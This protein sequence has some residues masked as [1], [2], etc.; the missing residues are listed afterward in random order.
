MSAKNRKIKKHFCS[1][2]TGHSRDRSYAEYIYLYSCIYLGIFLYCFVLLSSF[3][4]SS[5]KFVLGYDLL[6]FKNIDK[7][8]FGVLFERMFLITPI[9]AVWK[10]QI[11]VVGLQDFFFFFPFNNKVLTIIYLGMIFELDKHIIF[12]PLFPYIHYEICS[13]FFPFLVTRS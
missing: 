9:M 3:H 4:V 6:S 8:N 5:Q 10:E 13:S 1:T 12:A 2:T 11:S 7:C